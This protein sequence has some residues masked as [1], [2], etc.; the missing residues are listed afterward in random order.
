M[1][2]K[3]RE[4]DP[5]DVLK[6]YV[7]DGIGA[8]RIE[9]NTEIAERMAALGMTYQEMA[10]IYG[11]QVDTISRRVKDDSA[12]SEAVKRGA[13]VRKMSLRRM[14][15]K[16]ARLEAEGL[17]GSATMLVWLG[18]NE[19]GQRQEVNVN[20]SGRRGVAHVPPPATVDEWQEAYGLP[21]GPSE[22]GVN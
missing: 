4:P 8:P 15:Y 22:P 6:T 20:V 1:A 3:V 16:R 19:L 7:Q 14:Q 17:V 18:R 5:I 21:A 10:D 11:V 12:F 13:A 2:K 9:L